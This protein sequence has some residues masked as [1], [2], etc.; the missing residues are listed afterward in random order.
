MPRSAATSLRR[1]TSR[2]D[3]E[4]GVTLLALVV[5]LTRLP[6]R[7]QYLYGWDG[8]NYALALRRFD[9]AIEQPHL[10]GYPLYVALASV[11][12]RVTHEPAAAYVLLSILGSI[13]AVVTLWLLARELLGQRLATL[14]ALLLVSSPLFWYWGEVQSPYVFLALG[15]ALVAWGC[16]RAME[17]D[18]RPFWLAALALGLSGGVRPDLVPFLLPLLLFTAVEGRQTL[19]CTVIAGAILSA[20]VLVWLIP[21]I[22]AMGGLGTAL[23]LTRGQSAAALSLTGR[24]SLLGIDSALRVA[25]RFV[26]W[27]VWG[28][29]PAA[30]GLALVRPVLR[31]EIKRQFAAGF[32]AAWLTPATLFYLTV[33]LGQ[34]GYVL[35]LLPPLLILGVAG[36]RRLWEMVRLRPGQRRAAWAALLAV[37]ALLFLTV[38]L[39]PA[40]AAI[41][42]DDRF[43]QALDSHLLNLSAAGIAFHDQWV[44]G[45]VQPLQRAAP[46]CCT[47]LV[48]TDTNWLRYPQYY[49]PDYRQYV[50]LP[51]PG[52]GPPDFEVFT[53]GTWQ[54]QTSATVVLPPDVSTLVWVGQPSFV[55]TGAQ[56]HLLP[57]PGAQVMLVRLTQP[58]RYGGYTFYPFAKAPTAAAEIGA[59]TR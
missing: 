29:G 12:A 22:A 14:T 44:A 51:T 52:D 15:S 3:A 4:L 59:L 7:S 25:A 49:L 56:L 23:S 45:V 46:P 11:V 13:G 47:A 50:F 19:R 37:N 42:A 2:H 17:G 31:R 40:A 39:A 33:H 41:G 43:S 8:V 36:L 32:F 27:V 5:L 28:M 58:L 54:Q 9:P 16:W 53:N 57:A 26:A 20:A 35:T 21:L 34:P 18:P 10:P 48:L 30:A 38:Q 6:F 24:S 55:T 1:L